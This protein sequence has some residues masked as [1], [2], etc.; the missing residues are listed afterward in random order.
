MNAGWYV[1]G[2][3]DELF[4]DGFVGNEKTKNSTKT[5]IEKY[6]INLSRL[7]K[8]NKLPKS[9][10]RNKEIDACLEILE[11]RQKRNIMLIGHPGVGKSN[12]VEGLAQKISDKT[13]YSFD[14]N[15]IVSG[16]KY[17]GDLEKRI[18]Y[19]VDFLKKEDVIGF[20]DEAHML[21]NGV[22]YEDGISLMNVLKPAMA[23]NEV[24]LIFATTHSE[25]QRFLDQDKAFMR[26][27]TTVQINETNQQTTEL[28][29]N[30]FAQQHNLKIK[31]EDISY[32]YKNTK[33]YISNRYMPDVAIEVLDACYAKAKMSEHGK[34]ILDV[35]EKLMAIEEKK[36]EIV[37]KAMYDKVLKIKKEEQEL[38]KL[39]SVNKKRLIKKLKVNQD[40]INKVFEHNFNIHIKENISYDSYKNDLTVFNKKIIGQQT[41][42][43]QILERYLISQYN[44]REKPTSF[45]LLGPTGVGKTK[46]VKEIAKHFYNN[47]LLRIDCSEYQSSH[48]IDNL[49]G[50]PTGYVGNEKGGVLTNHLIN[51]PYS[52]VLFD[53]I[54][55]AHPSMYNLLLSMLDEG[56]IKDKKGNTAYAKNALIFFTSNIGYSKSS[57][58]IGFDAKPFDNTKDITKQFKKEFLNRLDEIVYYNYLSKNDYKKFLDVLIQ[59]YRNKYKDIRINFSLSFKEDIIN[60]ASDQG[61]GIRYLENIF[62]KDVLKK[63]VFAKMKK[64]KTVKI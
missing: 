5:D 12:V 27:C 1:D 39:L 32:L 22:G 46:T 51:N 59:K 33:K 52:V 10:G 58:P 56:F 60:T 16:T 6:A 8:N 13:I 41:Q 38:N 64:Q 3:E 50:S 7:A 34:D 23:R 53:E 45:F 24:Q 19:I 43:T 26:R 18:E 44:E 47:N 49:I 37:D 29:L 4:I 35:K 62:E 42:I 61:Y 31:K 40:I 48:A 36:Y 63:I 14:P 28:I 20:F 2:D 55:K 9:Y 54:E 30:K 17:R 25:H 21:K 15:K 11:K 57:T